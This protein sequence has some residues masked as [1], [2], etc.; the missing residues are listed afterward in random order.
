MIKNLIIQNFKCFEEFSTGPLS[1]VTLVGGKNNV[2]KSALLEAFWVFMN[3]G[4]VDVFVRMLNWRGIDTI[5]F[6]PESLWGPYFFDFDMGKAIEIKAEDT[7]GSS[8]VMKIAFSRDIDQMS[9]PLQGARGSID[10]AKSLSNAGAL[11]FSVSN[12]GYGGVQSY[13]YL[14]AGDGVIGM[15]GLYRRGKPLVYVPARGR[16]HPKDEAI[17]FGQIEL[18]GRKAELIEVLAKIEPE[19]EDMFVVVTTPGTPVLYCVLKNNR[20]MPIGY[21]GDGLSR[22]CAIVGAILSTEDGIVL[23]D[24]VENGIHHSVLTMLWKSIFEA[25]RR[26]NCQFIATTHSYECISSAVKGLSDG[27]GEGAFSYVRVEKTK[28]GIVAKNYELETLSAA[29]ESEWEIR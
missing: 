23:V 21:L 4:D 24:E 6:K 19:L 7:D 18:A 8:E 12:S 17:V 11:A 5:T 13:R 25:T 28:K 15:Q 10:T 26:S 14:V 29:L 22:A 16:G 3:R 27:G 2:G 1:R 9:T 20:K